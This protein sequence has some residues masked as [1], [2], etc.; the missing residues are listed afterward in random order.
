MSDQFAYHSVSPEDRAALTALNTEYAWLVDFGHAERIPELFT[1]DC[2]WEP[3]PGYPGK[4]LTGRGEMIDFWKRRADP[5]QFPFV[6]QRLI[7]NLRFA[8]DG[9]T[10]A[11]GWV[12]F[13]EYAARIG[14]KASATPVL[15]GNWLDTY[16]KGADGKWRFRTRKVSITFGGLNV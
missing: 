13:T 2:V 5:S 3:P 15:V 14:E 12:S 7:S 11:R 16:A 10:A 8:M 9:P 4:T 1:D 6:S